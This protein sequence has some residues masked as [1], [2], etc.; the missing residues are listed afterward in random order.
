MEEHDVLRRRLQRLPWNRDMALAA[1]VELRLKQPNRLEDTARSIPQWTTHLAGRPVEDEM[2]V[3]KA[4]QPQPS[5]P[6]LVPVP[7]SLERPVLQPATARDD[8]HEAMLEAMDE[9]LGHGEE[10]DVQPVPFKNNT[11]ATEDVVVHPVETPVVETNDTSETVET[12]MEEL[13]A[14]DVSEPPAVETNEVRE[15]VV[16]EQDVP[17][18]N[19]GIVPQAEVMHADTDATEET[20]EAL[21]HLGALLAAMGLTAMATEVDAQG[22]NAIGE[23]RRGLAQHVNVEP[24]DVRVARLLRLTLR[25]LPEGNSED[26][27]RAALLASLHTL[28]PPLKRW[29]RRRLEARHSGAKGNFL[30]D[31]MELGVALNRIPG[32]GKRVPLE[33]DA[34][35]LPQELAGLADEVRRPARLAA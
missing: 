20:A 26:G 31:A 30:A 19:E 18:R 27:Q 17:V 21:R 7:E 11:P 1:Q 12:E 22:M 33:K 29:M 24:R 32:L 28:I 9:Q 23:V 34:W 14:H 16:I 8:A 35:P 6:T 3:L 2:F 13:V 4:W 10:K 25:L 5:R 15:P